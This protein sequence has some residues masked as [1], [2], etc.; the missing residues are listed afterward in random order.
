M[1]KKL[2]AA[3]SLSV[4]LSGGMWAQVSTAVQS[5]KQQPAILQAA[6]DPVKADKSV[7]RID[8]KV[9]VP[10]KGISGEHRYIVRFEEEP[11]A[12][13]SGKIP[14]LASSQ[15]KSLKGALGK[16]GLGQKS[17][18]RF[19]AKS[20]ESQAYVGYLKQR[21]VEMESQISNR[22]GR[23]LDV[24]HRF[25]S[26]I[27]GV[28]LSMTQ[29]EAKRVS[30][31]PGI[32]KIQRDRI[33]QLQTDRGPTYIEAPFIWD[34]EANGIAAKGEGIV[35]AI[36][37]SGING[38]HPSFAAVASDGYE[39]VNPLGDGTYL[40]I[41]NPVSAD[42]D[43][44]V[45]CNSKLIGRYSFLEASITENNSEDLDGHGSHVA[46]TAG[47]NPV[48]APVFDTEGTPTGLEISISGVAPRANIIALEVC[49][50][51][52][53]YTSDRVA[54]L[55]QI[56]AD[57]I[58][59]VVNHSIGST[60]P[61]NSSPW[62]D[63]M[64]LAW[65][66]ARAAGITIANS[67]GNNGPDPATLGGT[68][69]P[70]ITNSGN[71]T[72][73]RAIAPKTLEDM[74]GG[75]T[76]PPANITGAA[77]SGGVGPAP[78]VFA[79]DYE[80]GDV[81]PEQCL[82]PFPAGTWT[83]EIVMCE[84]GT[85]A[86]VDKCINVREGGA[87]GCILANVAGGA[88]SLV[89]DAHVIPAIQISA[90]DGEAVKAWLASG[91]GHT[92]VISNNLVPFGS[93]PA[94]GGIASSGTSRGPN[95]SQ[96]YLPVSVGAP[97][98][99]IYAALHNGVEYGFLSGTSMASP[100]TAGATALMKQIHP[101]WTDAEILSALMTTANFTGAKKEDGETPA[102]PFDVGGGIIQ[103]S[104][105]STAGLLLD[106]TI[107][108]FE[109]ADP[110]L[111]GDPKTLN[112]AGLLTRACLIECTWTRSFTATT[113]GT[114]S[115]A[116]SAANVTAQPASFS[117]AAGES[118]TVTVTVDAA[119]LEETWY[120]ELVTLT[121][122]GD[123][124]EQHLTVSYVPS[125]GVL[126]EYVALTAHRDADSALIEGLTAAAID[127]LQIELTGLVAPTSTSL[128]LAGDS[129]N[130]TP[131]D[132]LADGVF[133]KTIEVD[134]TAT[135]LIAATSDAT[136]T[137]PDLD[138]YIGYDLDGDGLPGDGEIACISA[139]A[140]AE[141]FCD[142]TG[143][144]P[145]TWWVL[146]QNW[147]ASD[148]GTDTAE[149]KTT[150]VAGDA[151]N[152]SV[153][154]PA[155]VPELEPFD[156]R[157]LWDLEN[158]AEGD[159]L[160]GT[161]TLGA[162]AGDPAGIGIIPVEL[163]RSVDDV[164]FAASTDTAAAGDSVSFLAEIIPNLT[165]SDRTYTVTAAIPDGMTLVDGS[166][167][168]G[169]EVV[170]DKIVWTVAMPSLA[171]SEPT[172][173]AVTSEEDAA[174]AAPFAN[175]GAY[176]DLE[177]F[178]ILPDTTVS[179]DSVSF[180]AFSS[181]NFN[182]YGEDFVGGMNFTDDGFVFFNSS[183]GAT[184]WENTPIPDVSDPNDLI[185]VLWRDMV[186]PTPSTTPGEVAGVTL[187]SAG[188][189]VTI[190]EYDNMKLYPGDGD[191][192]IDFEVAIMGYADD[193]PGAYEIMV[194]FD[195]INVDSSVGTIGVENQLGTAGTQVAFNDVA[196][197]NGMAICYDL[198][199]PAY[200]AAALSF[201]ATVDAGI[202]DSELSVALTSEVDVP[203]T[204]AVTE[205]V[206][207]AVE[208]AVSNYRGRFVGP[209]V[210]G[211]VV[212]KG[213]FIKPR[214][215]M[216]DGKYRTIEPEM[217]LTILRANGSVLLSKRGQKL[218]SN[219]IYYRNIMSRWMKPGSYTMQAIVD[220]EVI[221]EVEYTIQ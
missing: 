128:S 160:Y 181:Q 65:L 172:Y 84:R 197:A 170:G 171:D 219:K 157:M 30:S 142:V 159:T 161:I 146:V 132:N 80:N 90:E 91:T 89:N 184:P 147:Q 137:S 37:D 200:D 73:D 143:I 69:A 140:S 62:E 11:L 68:G 55:D 186:I 109:A 41:C 138:I 83:N 151:G 21:Q 189:D 187:A 124:P 107:A 67:A 34:G 38:D 96:D 195:N 114:W 95:L 24:K 32:A 215:V 42:Y 71:F 145:G 164:A 117:L 126:P 112:L 51:D 169:G 76:L 92:G 180:S 214:L 119:G 72:H 47:G 29:E 86:R 25:Q 163:T 115:V 166:I 14:G 97:G 178:G 9:F 19:N 6:T 122:S 13:Y 35:I 100:H 155:A 87:A 174:C 188:P 204:E 58:V 64:D 177:Q 127:D 202:A 78:I 94:L 10:E 210:D 22:L 70:W 48:K 129:D 116:T 121:P 205:T 148:A 40:G 213:D 45:E 33:D 98:T 120:H 211:A 111:G 176:T 17:T 158:V 27:N 133:F 198:V 134:E 168:A 43:A 194:A 106:E 57:G 79:G 141:E 193:T 103:L 26:A 88:T 123:L 36:M 152:A 201:E 130:S 63:A 31:L 2:L 203:G 28:T 44:E 144:F 165:T 192:S 125:N 99:D 102:D 191:D 105:A 82:T 167:S 149:L 59:D 139:T 220:G 93:D 56:I 209:F 110:A 20:S 18:T 61:V 113:A 75:D 39:H 101:E 85:I 175:S 81:D 104:K 46:S 183:Q 108:N 135:R 66:S 208:G 3:A 12:T 179:G 4:M 196:I 150:L 153:T 131:F 52:G 136:S 5:T 185:A 53:C 50:E 190:V 218:Y 199:Q 156:L 212:E 162:S 221:D 1:N 8:K 182:F 77:L 49:G 23:S 173:V 54:A 154:G 216:F 7:N 207:I 16:S 74:T 206:S 118:Q 217:T 15:S 60:T